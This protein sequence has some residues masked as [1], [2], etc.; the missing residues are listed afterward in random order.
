MSQHELVE[1]SSSSTMVKDRSSVDSDRGAVLAWLESQFPAWTVTIDTTSGWNGVTRELW[2]ARQSGHHPQRE[3]TPGKLH[4]RLDD[5][6]ERARQRLA[7]APPS[8]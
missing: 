6:E 3:L 1:A 2:E 4:R 5:Y 8:A 7:L